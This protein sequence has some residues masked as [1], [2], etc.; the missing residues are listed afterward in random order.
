VLKTMERLSKKD[1]TGVSMGF[2]NTETA[3]DLDKDN[4]SG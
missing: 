3:G 1:K 2:S 4:F